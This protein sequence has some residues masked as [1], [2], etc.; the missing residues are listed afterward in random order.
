MTIAHVA[1]EPGGFN[2]VHDFLESLVWDGEP[3]VDTWLQTYVGAHDAPDE[4]LKAVAAATLIGGVARIYRPGVKND[5]ALVFEGGQGTLKS[6]A[7]NTLAMRDD[8]FS[9]S[10]PL[11][12]GHKDA[13][14]H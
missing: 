3:R 1:R 8:W 9:D 4:Y 6:T 12:L 11:D 13:R 2:P 14:D 7:I 10:L 5:C